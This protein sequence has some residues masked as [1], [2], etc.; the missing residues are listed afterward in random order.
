MRVLSL[1]LSMLLAL[2]ALTGVLQLYREIHFRVVE[3]QLSSP[4]LSTLSLIE[5]GEA[6]QYSSSKLMASLYDPRLPRLLARSI[7]RASFVSQ[8]SSELSGRLCESLRHLGETIR[9]E[10]E[11]PHL[12]LAW[13]EV[14]HRALQTS[15]SCSTRNRP[16]PCWHQL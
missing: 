2:G 16:R 15:T 7:Y 9:G 8:E 10:P 5:L 1:T 12:L 6:T 11:N 4:D 14:N 13:L 3:Q